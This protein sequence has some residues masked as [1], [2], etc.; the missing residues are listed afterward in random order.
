MRWA[1]KVGRIAGIDIR[2]H[3]TFLAL[4]AWV[5]WA[6]YAADHSVTA[7]FTGVAFI[8]LVFGV[9]VLHELG[10]AL[11]ARKFGVSTRDIT[12]LPIGGVAALE[13]MPENPKHELLVALAGPAVNVLLAIALGLTLIATGQAF[14]P[15]DLVSPAGSLLAQLLWINV[16]LAAFNLL[17]AFPMDGG[18]ALRALL[19]MRIGDLRATQTAAT[20]G[21]AL[22]LAFGFIGLFFNPLLLFIALFVWLGASGEARMAQVKY[23]MDGI[24]VE[25]AMVR[26]IRALRP[27]DPIGTAIE[28][29]LAGFQHDFPVVRDG[30]VVGML[31]REDLLHGLS[32]VGPSAR[33]ADFMRTDF[34]VAHPWE[35]L[36]KT[37]EALQQSELRSF[38]VTWADGSLAGVVS[39]D[40]IGELLLVT[41]ALRDS[42]R[43][44]L[45]SYRVDPFSP[46]RPRV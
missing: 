16:L 45:R 3:V 33:V 27:G 7:A 39:L 44:P 2:I 46:R 12:L 17:P 14:V 24:A 41:A 6:H 43:E 31:T 25:A 1:W 36:D 11:V 23:A 21:Q 8:L 30:E 38:P 22:A 28:A 4:L 20:L 26:S 18:R 5:A 32:K 10:H 9:V 19:A 40:T 13:R 37:F 34:R 29:T 42:G 15:T 35:M